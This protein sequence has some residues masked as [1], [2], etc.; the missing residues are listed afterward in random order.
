MVSRSEI[1]TELNK[2]NINELD[3][4]KNYWYLYAVIIDGMAVAKPGS[5]S[6]NILNRIYKYINI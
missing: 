5:S 6:V 3:Y 1:K 4:A 2:L